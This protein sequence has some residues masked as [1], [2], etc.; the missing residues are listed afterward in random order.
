MKFLLIQK[1]THACIYF[2]YF[3]I[4]FRQT[5]TIQGSAKKH[6]FQEG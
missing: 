4:V 5:G 1:E 2:V 3:I 6:Y